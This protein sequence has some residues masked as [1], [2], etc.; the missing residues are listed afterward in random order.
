MYPNFRVLYDNC[1]VFWVDA[2]IGGVLILSFQPS[3]RYSKLI[4]DLFQW[5]NTRDF[6]GEIYFIY[7]TDYTER[8]VDRI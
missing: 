6:L 1:S 8:H 2:S 7:M 3:S 4:S 5:T